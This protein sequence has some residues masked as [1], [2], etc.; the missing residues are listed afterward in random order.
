MRKCVQMHSGPTGSRENGLGIGKA[1]IVLGSPGCLNIWKSIKHIDN[2][3][4]SVCVGIYLGMGLFVCGSL[5]PGSYLNMP[6]LGFSF[7]LFP[8]RF[9][10]S[11]HSDLA[12][13]EWIISAANGADN[14]WRGHAYNLN[15][16]MNWNVREYMEEYKVIYT[17]AIDFIIKSLRLC[18]RYKKIYLSI[19]L[20]YC[21]SNTNDIFW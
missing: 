19:Y 13:D 15:L 6:A 2:A 4:V 11:P 20:W 7:S 17:Y 16:N 9:F 12:P 14:K 5:H 10:F 3:D 21:M 1:A 8:F 18:L